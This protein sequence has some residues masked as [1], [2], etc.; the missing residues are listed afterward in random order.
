[1]TNPPLRRESSIS[2]LLGRTPSVPRRKR[3]P[4]KSARSLSLQTQNG[5]AI[6]S[7]QPPLTTSMR[8]TSVSSW[9]PQL[10]EV[11]VRQPGTEDLV[12]G[13]FREK[14]QPYPDALFLS[15]GDVQVMNFATLATILVTPDNPEQLAQDP[16]AI[17]LHPLLREAAKKALTTKEY[18]T[19]NETDPRQPYGPVST[20]IQWATLLLPTSTASLAFQ[21]PCVDCNHIRE[22]SQRETMRVSRLSKKN[23]FTCADIG[24]R[25]H[26]VQESDGFFTMLPP[27]S[28]SDITLLASPPQPKPIEEDASP[29]KRD[30]P[31]VII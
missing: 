20:K 29:F 14:A 23:P 3:L 19:M 18:L 2:A 26:K 22:I 13:W 15:N 21:V 27:S 7:A 24:L 1:M 5:L 11:W 16:R 25:C 9:N 6:E 12:M 17:A 4:Q 30:I 10:M 8:S 28:T 31:N